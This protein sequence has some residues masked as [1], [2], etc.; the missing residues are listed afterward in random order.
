MDEKELREEPLYTCES[1]VDGEEYKKTVLY[2]PQ[3]Y[4]EYVLGGSILIACGSIICWIVFKSVADALIFAVVCEILILIIC[5]VTLGSYAEQIFKNNQKK[6]LSDTYIHTEFY[7]DY[8]IRQGETVAYKIKYSDIIKYIETPENIYMKSGKKNLIVI[9]QKS[10]CTPEL[11]QFIGGKCSNIEKHFRESKKPKEIKRVDRPIFV[12]RA[13]IFL[14]IATLFS[15]LGAMLTMQFTLDITHAHGFDFVKMTW[16]FW[17]WLPIPLLSIILGIKYKRAGLKCTKNIVAGV[18][19]GFLLA[20]YGAFWMIPT[21]SENYNQNVS[22]DYH[23]LDSYKS[24]LGV[25][26]PD[27]GDLTRQ[28]YGEYFE[29][30][31]TEY[32][33]ISVYYDQEDTSQ[34][35]A[36]MIQNENWISGAEMKSNLKIY[37]PSMML[38]MYDEKDYLSFYNKTLGTYNTLPEKSGNYEVYAMRYDVEEKYLEIC[39]FKYTYK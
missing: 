29:P 6:G 12:S 39:E 30:D 33:Q 21:F 13:L 16:V 26:L 18:I 32:A 8:F 10:R 22:Q 23:I 7:E 24:I 37:M 38:H 35:E 4:W 25:A 3:V 36:E 17:L 11:I 15:L 34:L 20:V 19:M 28:Y 31:K 2:F 1:I 27:N 5:K 9:F 14:F